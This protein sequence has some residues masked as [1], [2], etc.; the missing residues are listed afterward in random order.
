MWRAMLHECLP[1]FVK[2]KE[3]FVQCRNSSKQQ[4]LC[5]TRHRSL[6][7]LCCII[8][9]CNRCTP[10][11]PRAADGR[12]THVVPR[13]GVHCTRQWICVSLLLMSHMLFFI[14]LS[15]AEVCCPAS[16]FYVL[17]CKEQPIH[18]SLAGSVRGIVTVCP[19]IS[20]QAILMSWGF[21]GG[22]SGCH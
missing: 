2:A 21:R 16:A 19:A 20:W 22:D 11:I 15:G 8:H 1:L 12:A 9:S 6:V 18:V 7:P 17:N 3:L 13:L 14:G 10:K 5:N 4:V